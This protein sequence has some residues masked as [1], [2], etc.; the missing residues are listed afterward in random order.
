MPSKLLSVFLLVAV[1]AGLPALEVQRG[2]LKLVINERTGRYTVWGAEDQ[3][4]PVWTPL[5]LAE[6]PTTSKWKLQVGDKTVVLG[7]D[8]SFTIATEA[9][10]TGAKVTWTSK[11]LVATL[12]FDFLLSASS[13]VADG[14]KLDLSVVNVGDA[15]V[16]L[17]VRWVLDTNLGE[18]KDHFKLSTGETVNTETKLEGTLP[19]FW[20]SN[21][22][23]DDQ[24]GLIVMVGKV[25]TPPVRVV[26]SNWKRLDDAA[27]DPV[28]KQGRDFNLLPYSFNDSAVAQVYET[29]DL[30]AGATREVVVALGLK[31]AGTLVG[32]RV[33]SAN[34]LDDLLKKNQNP[35]LGAIDQDL[36][37]L[38][39]LT[40]Q[41]DSKLADPN[42]VTPEDLKLLQAVLDQIDA[43]RKTLEASKP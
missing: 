36:A 22:P 29:Q 34:P 13:A 11:T 21:S 3:V 24:L 40:A 1:A 30:A 14:L 18:K 32:S 6:D 20:A 17:G 38:D 31:S 37:S 12:T 35:A 4:K 25:S 7:D 23:T 42:R 15:G 10:N 19:D 26:F 28:F 41:I 33:G 39:T 5:F 27:W 43:R 16:R 2:K 9:T 8:P